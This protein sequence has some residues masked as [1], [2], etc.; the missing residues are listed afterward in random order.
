MCCRGAGRARGPGLL[1]RPPPPHRRCFCRASCPLFW[2]VKL[3]TNMCGVFFRNGRVI[4][5]VHHAVFCFSHSGSVVAYVRSKKYPLAPPPPSPLPAPKKQRWT[6][7]V[8]ASVDRLLLARAAANAY[9]PTV[10]SPTRTT[11]YHTNYSSGAY[12][13]TAAKHWVAPSY[14]PPPPPNPAPP[15]LVTKVAAPTTMSTI[16][17][18]MSAV[19]YL[20]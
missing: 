19:Y 13:N 10:T 6:I 11:V 5:T 9:T 14:R 20:A 12:H 3:Y 16:D 8:C 17:V 15:P 7:S 18:I 1:R 2:E 4:F